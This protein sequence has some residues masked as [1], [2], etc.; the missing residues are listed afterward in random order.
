MVFVLIIGNHK[1]V[2]ANTEKEFELFNLLSVLCVPELVFDYR[3]LRYMRTRI[4]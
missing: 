4:L 1:Q 2:Q 3:Q